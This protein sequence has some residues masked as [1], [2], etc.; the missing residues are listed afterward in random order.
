MKDKIYKLSLCLALLCGV[1]AISAPPAYSYSI[2]THQAVVD[3]A[4]E[5]SLQPLLKHRYPGATADELQQAHAYAYGGAIVQDMG[6]FPFG[7]VLFTNLTHYVRSG[8]FVT[9]LIR[10]STTLDEYAFSLG[11]LAHYNSDIYGHPIATNKA[12]AL[13]YPKLKQAHGQEVTYAEDPV[14]HVKTEFGFDVLQ[15]AR[16]NYASE[17]YQRFI[18]FKVADK[19]LEKAFVETYGLELRDV[20]LSLPMAIGSYRYTIRGIFPDLTKAA[21][22]AKQSEIQEA[23]PTVTRQG[24]IYRM[25]R[26]SY[27]EAWGRDYE[28]PGLFTRLVAWVI[29]VLPKLGPLKPLAFTP[30]T[31]EAEEL[32]YKSFNTTVDNYSAHLNHMERQEPK[33]RNMELDTG[34][35]TKRGTYALADE[36]YAELLKKLAKRDFKDMS[37]DLREN[38]LTF[39][40]GAKAAVPSKDK[41]EAEK[42]AKEWEETSAYLLKLKSVQL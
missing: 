10:A 32:F 22:Q 33:L 30:P 14:S 12:V 26:N 28:R 36:T 38:L 9:N 35:P 34:K 17:E 27:H 4:W 5:K 20:F 16:G 24:F 15:V 1:W 40:A 41:K 11:A 25:S 2:L 19:S 6:Y 29:R 18:G 42:A 21:W 37:P 31:P 3:A 8:D 7:S 39:Y 23:R 13:V